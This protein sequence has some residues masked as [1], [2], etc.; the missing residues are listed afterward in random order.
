MARREVLARFLLTTGS[1]VVT[2]LL[3]EAPAFLHMLDYRTIFGSFDSDSAL[4]VTGREAD[5]ELLW[6]HEPYHEY[7][8]PYQGNLGAALCVP[9]DPSQSVTVRYDRHGFRNSRNLE[10][11]DI[12]VLGDSNIEGYLTPE[13]QLTTTLLSQLQGKV[14]A[15]LGHSGYGPQQELVV[16]KRYG[17]PL[18]P[19]TVIWTF[20]EGN[21]LSDAEQYDRQRDNSRSAWWQNVWYRS[22]IRNIYARLLQP[23]DSCTPSSHIAQFQ[24][25]FRD[26]QG[27]VSRVWFAPSE[28]QP[29]SERQLQKTLDAITE[30]AMLC[31]ERNI[32]FLVA[33]IPEKYRVYQYLSN[34]EFVSDA[35]QSWRVSSLPEQMGTRLTTLGLDIRYVDL[36]P[37]LKRASG[38]GMA[39]YLP[40]DTHW[41]DQGNR[42]VAEA[43]DQALRVL[44]SH[45]TTPLHSSL[46]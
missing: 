22:L 25:H 42:V 32:R 4:T 16:L 18:Q 39:T 35:M 17:L 9:P 19:E 11:A 28:V 27:R 30:A 36:T 46:P 44:F 13:E 43:L 2:V 37:A 40:D 33:F 3:V 26:E 31:R 5:P 12:V 20:F 6:K 15:N 38:R 41:T 29:I 34:V 7:D 10:R 1:L 45:S 24:A 8:E 21:D 23:T 14:V